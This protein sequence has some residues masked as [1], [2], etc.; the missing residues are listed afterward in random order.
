MKKHRENKKYSEMSEEDRAALIA[1]K[2]AEFE[3]MKDKW[4][5]KVSEKENV[6]EEKASAFYKSIQKFTF[7]AMTR[8]NRGGKEGKGKRGGRG[9]KLEETNDEIEGQF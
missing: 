1:K 3:A 2:Q 9:R 8:N 6:S 4:M 7:G 5:K